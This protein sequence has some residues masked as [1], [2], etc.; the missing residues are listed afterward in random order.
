MVAA[1]INKDLV[2]QFA[3]ELTLE[4]KT[5]TVRAIREKN[6]GRGSL[7]T[8]APILKEWRDLNKEVI[9]QEPMPEA[10]LL[11]AMK[12]LWA[13]LNE[14]AK[15]ELLEKNKLF[16]QEEDRLLTEI[17]EFADECDQQKQLLIELKESLDARDKALF[18]VQKN[19]EDLQ[20]KNVELVKKMAVLDSE[21]IDLK[22]T[23][24]QLSLK[25]E[26]L[27]HDVKTLQVDNSEQY[28]F[29][30]KLDVKC[31]NYERDIEAKSKQLVTTTSDLKLSKANVR[32]VEKKLVTLEKINKDLDKS[33]TKLEIRNDD[34]LLSNNEL[35]VEKNELI[36]KLQLERD[37]ASKKEIEISKLSN[38]IVSLE[39]SFKDTLEAKNDRIG[40]L[41]LHNGQLKGDNI[42][43]QDNLVEITKSHEKQNKI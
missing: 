28:Q 1:T 21:I 22:N 18:E 37:I 31:A 14:Q 39:R 34:L 30:E 32:R 8:I 25:I 29:I 27:D 35:A 16:E 6:G 40:E 9:E 20:L 10:L 26:G 38:K 23:K 42:K 13:V 33:I 4:E 19:Y 5:V 24:S 17:L 7:A 12:P 3:D 41:V 43:L 36:A 15:Q 2:F 11:N